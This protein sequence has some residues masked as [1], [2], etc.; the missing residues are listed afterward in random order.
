MMMNECPFR[1]VEAT[2]KVALH[3]SQ[4]DRPFEAVQQYINSLLFR[5]HED[6]EGVPVL[7]SG[8]KFQNDELYGRILDEFPWIHVDAMCNI[9]ILVSQGKTW[10][11]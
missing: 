7:Y 5:Y 6:L 2:L 8:L 11:I 9:T 3:P 10:L 1:T 4:I